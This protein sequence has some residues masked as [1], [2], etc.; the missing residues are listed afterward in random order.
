MNTRTERASAR[1]E[2]FAGRRGS[3]L[4]WTDAIET[5]DPFRLAIG[6]GIGIVFLGVLGV[7][8]VKTGHPLEAFNLDHEY[9]VPATFSALLDLGAAVG[10]EALRRRTGRNVLFGLVV[11][12]AFMA[13]DEY[14]S[15]H[16][17]LERLTGIDWLKL[18]TPIFLYAAVAWVAVLNAFR[19]KLFWLCMVGGAAAWSI[20]Q[21]FELLEWKGNVKQP[22]YYAMM[23]PEELLEMAGSGLFLLGM[24][25]ALR[26]YRRR[27][28]AVA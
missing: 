14:A 5:V 13:L 23:V 24:L 25:I 11:L 6:I 12:F 17:H 2:V 7:A 9:T 18:Y 10:A 26:A 1:S 20:A 3:R 16:E 19:D 8:E 27:E 22:H 15:I 28:S 4:S 21:V